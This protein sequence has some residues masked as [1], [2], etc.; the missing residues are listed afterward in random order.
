MAV[1]PFERKQPTWTNVVH[2][3]QFIFLFSLD[4]F[5]TTARATEPGMRLTTLNILSDQSRLTQVIKDVS[6]ALV[7]LAIVPGIQLY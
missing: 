1:A 7:V 2:R 5:W 3:I 6:E 4:P